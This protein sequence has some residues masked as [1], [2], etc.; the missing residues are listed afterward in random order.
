MWYMSAVSQL[1]VSLYELTYQVVTK[2][3]NTL[4]LP[5]NSQHHDGP[6]DGR[7][8][9]ADDSPALALYPGRY[10]TAADNGEDLDDAEGNIEQDGLK[11]GIAEGLDD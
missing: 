3:Q 5:A 8:R 10:P 11:G 7:D 6:D 1:C 2:Q 9:E 4:F